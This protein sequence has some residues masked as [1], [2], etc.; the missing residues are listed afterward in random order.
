[1]GSDES[2]AVYFGLIVLTSFQ[3]I[4]EPYTYLCSHPGK[5]IRSQIMDAFNMWFNC[6][7]QQLSAIKNVVEMLHNASLLYVISKKHDLVFKH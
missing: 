3:I 1:M 4:L 7:E 2:D 6:P 5:S